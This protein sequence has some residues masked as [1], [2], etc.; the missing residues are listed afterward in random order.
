M[1]FDT[2]K[3]VA[4]ATTGIKSAGHG[5]GGYF[6]VEKEMF[7]CIWLFPVVTTGERS[8]S[9]SISSATKPLQHDLVVS[10]VDLCDMSATT[11][12]IETVLTAMYPIAIEFFLRMCKVSGFAGVNKLRMDEI[13]H[14]LD[15]NTVGYAMRFNISIV[16]EIIYPCP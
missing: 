2:V 15:E 6:N 14:A 3:T 12:Q 8:G 1:I 7:P 10:V 5:S 9:G 13:I 16:E 4:L 11:K